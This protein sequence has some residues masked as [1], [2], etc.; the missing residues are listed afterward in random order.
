LAENISKQLVT[1]KESSVQDILDF[2]DKVIVKGRNVLAALP[3]QIQG[4]EEPPPPSV[5]F[6]A[7][8]IKALFLMLANE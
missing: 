5:S 3:S 1:L 2:L 8:Q 4:G 7:R 6:E